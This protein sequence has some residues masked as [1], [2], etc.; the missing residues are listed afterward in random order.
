M[1]R[2]P[3]FICTT[4]GTQYAS[5][6][7]PPE[8]CDI[9][10]EERQ[11]VLPSGQF[12]V[13]LEEMQKSKKFMNDIARKEDGVHSLTTKPKFGIG[14][15]AYIVQGSGFNLLWDCITYLDDATLAEVDKLGS[16]DAIAISHPHYYSSQVEWAKALD[17]PVYIHEDDREWV[18][19]PSDHLQF[20]SGEAMKLA[21]GLSLRRL[22]GHFKGGTVLHWE[23]GN[24]GK[25]ILFTGDIIQVLPDQKRVSFMYSYPNLI[26]LPVSKVQD[27]ANRVNRLAFDRIYGAFD[28]VIKENADDAVQRSA[29]RYIDAIEG[30]L[31]NT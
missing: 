22:G 19:R 16:V 27:I 28:K 25:G 8:V 24:N 29:E 4:C 12:W 11:Y 10:E 6:E 23:K 15:T 21:E 1:N 26:P 7:T 9:C 13:T 14:Q 18:M 2:M 17:V 20:W 3:N 31:F 5:A 30:R